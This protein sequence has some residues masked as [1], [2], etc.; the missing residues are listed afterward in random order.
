MNGTISYLG[1]ASLKIVTN[2]NKVI[3]VDPYCGSENDYKDAA[4][5][6]LVTHEHFDHNKI[7]LVKNRKENCKIITEK[8]ALHNGEYQNIDLGYVKI[9]AVE[10]YN[11]HHNRDECVGYIL[12]LSNGKTIYIPG[13]TDITPTMYKLNALNLDFAFF[14]VDGFYTMSAKDATKIANEIGAKHNIPFHT[15][16]D[17]AFD[18]EKAKSFKAK[19]TLILKPGESVI[20]DL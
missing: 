16:P 13:D 1:H 20:I 17:V 4:D 19:N 2:E 12:T 11:S 5:L 18:M 9:Q 7:E 3:Y 10:S 8:Q 14:C 6:I 15:N